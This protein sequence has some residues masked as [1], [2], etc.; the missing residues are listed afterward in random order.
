VVRA[1]LTAPA[2]GPGEQMKTFA[3]HARTRIRLSTEGKE[4]EVVLTDTQRMKRI[5]I[6]VDREDRASIRVL[7]ADGKVVARIPEGGKDG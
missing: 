7:D 3:A 6:G 4:A 1:P 5:I 2:A